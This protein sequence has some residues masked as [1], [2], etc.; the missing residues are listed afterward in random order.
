MNYSKYDRVGQK[1]SIELL[2][3][4]NEDRLGFDIERVENSIEDYL[5]CKQTTNWYTEGALWKPEIIRNR[6]YG[7]GCYNVLQ[8]HLDYAAKHGLLHFG[9]IHVYHL[10]WQHKKIMLLRLQYMLGNNYCDISQ[11]QKSIVNYE[12]LA[13]ECTYM[14]KPFIKI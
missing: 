10:F 11:I 8:M 5:L 7:L 1:E 9:W 6:T 14:S 4:Y 12:D 13:K 3:F 2:S